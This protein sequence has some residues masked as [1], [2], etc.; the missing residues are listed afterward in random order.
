MSG[1]GTDLQR[2]TIGRW[3]G[4]LLALGID[5]CALSGKHGP[6]PVCGGKDRFRFDD[7][8]GRGTFFCS[9][10][11]AGDGA[12][13]VMLT[14][15]VDFKAAAKLVR[16]VL[17]GAAI[18]CGV[19]RERSPAIKRQTLKTIWS[20]SQ[21]VV[22]GDPVHTYLERRGIRAVSPMLR[23]AR[24]QPYFEDGRRVGV[25]EAMVAPVHGPDGKGRTLHLTYLQDAKKAPVTASR[26]T[27]GCVAPLT[28]SAIRLAD[29]ADGTLGVAEGI[30]TALSAAQM[31][32]IPTWATRDAGS[33]KTFEWPE[34]VRHLVVFGDNDVSYT[35]Q[36][37]AYALAHRA[38]GKGLTVEVK[39]P[40]DEG[41][42]WNDVLKNAEERV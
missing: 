3:P 37:A 31:F 1:S 25:Y 8:D 23:Y 40:R 17:P 7:K 22:A 24:A 32:G 30:E 27:M 38:Q 15:G 34:E 12:K 29:V 35:G 6:C 26:K 33:M 13:L 28:G 10:C 4:I 19:R 41:M 36:E 39:I 5:E 9:H 11:G 14:R 18:G 2:Q 16:E 42:D 20:N 21:P